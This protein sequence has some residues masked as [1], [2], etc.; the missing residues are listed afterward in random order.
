MDYY[1]TDLEQGSEDTADPM[2]TVRVLT[3]MLAEEY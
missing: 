3:I 2:Q 1:A